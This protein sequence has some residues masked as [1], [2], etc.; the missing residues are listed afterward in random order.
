M[1]AP[2]LVLGLAAALAPADVD[3]EWVAPADCPPRDAV[4]AAA[5][6]L[7]SRPAGA[8]P[9]EERVRARAVVTREPR[10]LRLELEL[11]SDAGLDRRTLRARGCQVLAD[12][13]AEILA[14]AAD[15][16][17][18]RAGV[19]PALPPESDGTWPEEP[20]FR[21]MPQN[22]PA[23]APAV[24]PA[25]A[26]EPALPADPLDPPVAPAPDPLDPPVPAPAPPDRPRASLRLA[27]V[28][29]QGSLPGPTGGLGL[30]VG[31][32]RR[33][34]RVELGFAGYVPRDARPDPQR[35]S[36]ARMSLWTASI[37]ACGVAGLRPRLELAACG[38]LEAGAL[39]GA[40]FGTDAARARAQPWLAAVVGPELAVPVARR[41]AVTLGV[42][43]VVA[44][45]RPLFVLDG[46][47]PVFRA[48]PAA[49]RAVLGVQLRI[50]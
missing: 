9:A 50:P 23:P 2:V 17:L 46:A 38:G 12:A 34:F 20:A 37:R 35:P 11:H 4:A 48:H 40:A 15:P 31:V 45:V 6:R 29:D 14:T 49:F 18:A 22:A 19:P 39:I 41:V 42:D 8:G 16:T 21:D 3:L 25:P 30:A 5:A 28:F 7:V 27:G 44:L 43:A 1:S 36:G 10:G 13:T 24:A 26:I 32:M 47:G 33:A